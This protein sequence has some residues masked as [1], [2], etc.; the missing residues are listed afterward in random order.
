MFHSPGQAIFRG[1]TKPK[2]SGF[3][4]VMGRGIRKILT[5]VKR[6][7]VLKLDLKFLEL[8]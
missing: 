2:I 1:K 4:N 3:E 8:K 6:F 5:F 7:N